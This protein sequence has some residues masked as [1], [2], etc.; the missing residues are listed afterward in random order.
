MD[1]SNICKTTRTYTRLQR[2]PLREFPSIASAQAFAQASGLSLPKW[3]GFKG[4]LLFMPK[5]L[6]F[7]LALR[8]TQQTATSW[9]L[10]PSESSSSA[11][12]KRHRCGLAALN[13]S[14]SQR[15]T[16][17]AE[18]QQQ[19]LPKCKSRAHICSLFSMYFQDSQTQCFN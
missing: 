3:R 7:A 8:L 18:E 6:T 13:T 1:C 10:C 4:P 16:K 11:F 14:C 5:A 2:A 15:T 9:W 19:S 17:P 12:Q